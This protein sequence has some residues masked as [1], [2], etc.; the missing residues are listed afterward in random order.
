[1]AGRLDARRG[2]AREKPAEEREMSTLFHQDFEL[3]DDTPISVAYRVTDKGCPPSWDDPGW[4]MEIEIVKAT[5]PVGDVELT[6]AESDRME[7]WLCE[8]HDPRDHFEG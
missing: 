3:D 8:N 5:T 1:M 2:V 4:S 6:F 7:A